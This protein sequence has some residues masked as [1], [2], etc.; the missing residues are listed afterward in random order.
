MGAGHDHGTGDIKH[1]KP[2]WW[3]FGHTTA[4]LIS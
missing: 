2:L 1:E 4:I 3:P